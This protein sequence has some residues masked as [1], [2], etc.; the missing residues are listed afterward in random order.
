MRQPLIVVG[1]ALGVAATGGVA[2]FAGWS[3][4]V[5]PATF[6]VYAARIP[7]PAPPRARVHTPPWIAWQ[8]LARG[9]PVDRYVVTRHLG[10]AAQVACEVPATARPRCTDRQAPAGYRATYTVAAA[11]GSHWVSVDS[12]PSAPVTVPGVGVPITVNGIQLRPGPDGTPVVV[13][14]ADPSADPSLVAGTTMSPPAPPAGRPPS[15]SGTVVTPAPRVSASPAPVVK[16]TGD[17]TSGGGPGSDPGA[18]SAPA[19]GPSPDATCGS[20]CSGSPSP[21]PPSAAA[22]PPAS[23]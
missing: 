2:A 18:A 22:P 16:S 20:R 1:A 4:T 9:V 5:Q 19:T 17:T 6:T 21:T 11:Y 3:V 13:G 8:P 7:Q 14:G 12:G 15:P 23:D 10:P